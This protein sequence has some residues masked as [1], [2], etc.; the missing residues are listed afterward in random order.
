MARSTKGLY[1][2]GNIW[3]MTYRDALGQQRFE[4]CKTQKKG[5][6]EQRLI[7]R[8]KEVIDGVVPSPK[9]HPMGLAAFLDDYAQHVAHQRGVRTKRLH[10]QHLTR[11]LGNPPLHTISVKML[12]RYR[13]LRRT[14]GAGPATINRELS[15]IKHVM[16]KA[17][18]WKLIAKHQREDLREV[19][20]D[21]EPP[22]R[23]RYL[24][25]K[26]EAQRLIDGC[27]GMFKALV[28]VALHTG[29]RRGELLSLPWENVDM[30]QGFIHLRATKT[31]EGRT[32]PMNETVWKVLANLRKGKNT[33]WVFHDEEN[34]PFRDT[35][36]KFVW[37]CKRAN[38][39]DF[40]FHDL[41]HTFA[42]WLVMDGVPL[43]T[44]SHLLGHK[45]IQMTMRYAHL[46]PEH[47]M[48][49]VRS[50]DKNLTIGG[51]EPDLWSQQSAQ[52]GAKH[53]VSA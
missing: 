26:D 6:A 31:G 30:D 19:Q 32:L 1:K 53:G 52:D 10:F 27:R 37:A 11:L 43:A 3:W 13:D 20:R 46:S 7:D 2:R 28:L 9:A 17:A 14:E 25:S 48:G 21:K 35:H 29:M 49:A 39:Q 4:S 12:E 15:T 34:R 51:F 50:L 47:R 23:L 45:S 18:S 8:R 44:V 5:E 24:G 40:R 16:T 42:S 38:I 36:K 33:S 22:G 41:R